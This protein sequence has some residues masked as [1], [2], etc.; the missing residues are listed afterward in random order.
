MRAFSASASRLWV[1]FR[2]YWSAS[3]TF[4]IPASLKDFIETSSTCTNLVVRGPGRHRDFPL[5][6]SP[7]WRR[8]TAKGGARRLRPLGALRPSRRAAEHRPGDADDGRYDAETH[9]G[10]KEAGGE[11]SQGEH[12]GALGP[13]SGG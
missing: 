7:E 8:R 5:S 6:S 2:T 10:R 1:W 13:G 9:E 12:A 3:T 4:M 11:R